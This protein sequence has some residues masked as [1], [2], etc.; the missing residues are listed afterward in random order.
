MPDLLADLRQLG[1]CHGDTVMAHAS[2]R[3]IGPVPGGAD[4]VLE[5]LDAAVGPGG[6]LLMVLGARDDWAWINELLE[7]ERRERLAEAEPFDPLRTP[8]EAE[9]G[10]L[11]EAFRTRPGTLVT[12]HPEGRFGAR[13]A[14]A[15]ELL[16]DPPWHDYYGPGSPLE[17][18]CELGGRVLRLGAD[19]DTVTLLHY[20]EYLVELPAKRRLRRLRRVLGPDGPT[21]RAVECLDDSNGIVDWPGEDYFALILGDYLATGA[22]RRGTVGR[23]PSELLDAADLVRFA[24]DWMARRLAG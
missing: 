5:A 2:L 10:Y 9:V 6:T 24:V 11:A 19:L 1:L 12:D 16:R 21:I 14:R 17:R 3:A 7:G 20:A 18:L 8:A 22:G 15:E 23:A 4:G 13:G